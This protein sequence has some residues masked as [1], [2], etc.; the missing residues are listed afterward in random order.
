MATL[1][2]IDRVREAIHDFKALISAKYPDAQ[3]D[4]VKGY[5]PRGTYLE[6][7][8]TSEDFEKAFDGIFDAVEDRL[9]E[10]QLQAPLPLFVMPI[11]PREPAG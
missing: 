10:L 5:D 4:V 3:F 6:V 8:V 7:T 9:V 2:K 1:R 11:R